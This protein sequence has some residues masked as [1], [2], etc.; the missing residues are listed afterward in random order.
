MKLKG[1]L[2]RTTLETTQKVIEL[3]QQG[4]SQNHLERTLHMTRKTIR[5]ILENEGI[6]RTKSGQSFH[7][8]LTSTL[9]ENA[10]DVLNDETAYWLGFLYADGYITNPEQANVIGVLL[11]EGDFK[12]IEKFK[13][14]LKAPQNIY[15]DKKNKSVKL[16][17][18]SQRLH[19]TLQ[20][21]GFTHNKSYD[22]KP[23][24]V[25]KYNRHFWRGVIDGDGHLGIHTTKWGT[26]PRVSICGTKEMVE[27]FKDFL[28]LSGVDTD[29]KVL[30][31]KDRELHTF[32]VSAG[33]ANGAAKILYENCNDYLD[34][35]YQKYLD[36]FSLN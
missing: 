16:K 10:F 26:Y 19:Q 30:K 11:Q 5:T 18:G 8:H 9:R 14:F 7:H 29:A 2:S 1:T 32:T 23:P 3:Y 25:L 27:G 31:E 22:A 34:R 33:L 24:E 20:N 6:K 12:H 15:Y 35:K 13:D 28:L 36:H 4:F 17:L 21:W